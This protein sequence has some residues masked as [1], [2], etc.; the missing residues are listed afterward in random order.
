MAKCKFCGNYVAD[1]AYV[2]NNGMCD[3]CLRSAN[4]EDDPLVIKQEDVVERQREQE[5]QAMLLA[6]EE[7]DKFHPKDFEGKSIHEYKFPNFISFE[8]VECED[9]ATHEALL[10]TTHQP[11]TT[12]DIVITVVI[13]LFLSPF[14]AA[15]IGLT[16]YV[17]YLL[18]KWW[19]GNGN[20]IEAIPF[21]VFL[22]IWDTS[23]FVFVY[24]LIL[25]RVYIF[26]WVLLKDNGIECYV[27]HK[28]NSKKAKRYEF[29]NLDV[30]V[31]EKSGNRSTRYWIELSKK[32][33]GTGVFKKSS[34]MEVGMKPEGEYWENF[35]KWYIQSRSYGGNWLS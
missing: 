13:G 33:A 17:I 30:R 14:V 4:G 11:M 2:L 16:G 7:K 25:R 8:I 26:D 31:V 6:N 28:F 1:E 21:A 29:N 12:I 23:V 22:C 5:R 35:L 10:L 18:V 32:D 27:G 24:K 9:T 34:R 15:A 19:Q 20:L 3:L